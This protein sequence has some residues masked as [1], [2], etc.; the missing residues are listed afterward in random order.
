M[1]RGVLC[2]MAEM[3]FSTHT[4][5]GL[6][7]NYEA[8][9]A[10]WTVAQHYAAIPAQ[11]H[12]LWRQLYQRQMQMAERYAAPEV[13]QALKQLDMADGIPDFD[14]LNALLK[15]STGFELVAVP[16]LIPGE[17]FFDHLA[18]RRFPAT[19]WIREQHEMD[20]LVEPDVFHDVFGHVPLL[21]HPAFADYMAMFG[22]KGPEAAQWDKSHPNAPISASERLNRL[23]WF[24]VEFGLVNADNGLKAYGA[25]ILSSFEET[26]YA[27]DSPMPHRLPFTPQAVMQ[28][29]YC[30]DQLQT[31]FFVLNHYDDLFATAQPDFNQLFDTLANQPDTPI[32]LPES[33]MV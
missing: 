29:A 4:T 2:V 24:T 12:A 10:D 33:N 15:K 18:H 8:K 6:R 28:Q 3:P 1:P 19:C 20:Y 21:M 5:H 11:Q 26:P 7:G 31:T 27:V 9:A 16:G 22:H 17:V 30:I 13:L 25:G 14:R 23:Y 32:Y